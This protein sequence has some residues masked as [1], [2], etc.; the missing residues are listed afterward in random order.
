MR[1]SM[2]DPATLERLRVLRRPA[3]P[4]ATSEGRTGKVEINGKLYT[5]TC[6]GLSPSDGYRLE[7][8]NRVY[9][10][11]TSSGV[12]L[13]DCADT[14]YRQRQCKHGLAIAKMREAGVV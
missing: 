8:G 1:R 13:C 2:P 4:T 6:H 9:D 12:P 10:L 3:Y 14:T 11:D 7:A 5:L